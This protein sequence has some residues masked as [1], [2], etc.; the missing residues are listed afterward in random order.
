MVNP[1]DVLQSFVAILAN[2][3]LITVAYWLAQAGF[4]AWLARERDRSALLW[5]ILGLLF[6]PLAVLAVG[7]SG[8]ATGDR[9]M[10]CLAC[11]EPIAAAARVCPHCRSDLAQLAEQ[12]MRAERVAELLRHAR[13]SR[14]IPP[15]PLP[16]TGVG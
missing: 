8:R 12:Q 10:P 9:Y 5:Y 16:D 3:L 11:R 2:L 7:L 15:A 4:A 6:G 13:T 1:N 14:P